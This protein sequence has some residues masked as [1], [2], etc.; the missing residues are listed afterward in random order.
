MQTSTTTQTTGNM[1]PTYIRGI[2]RDVYL[3]RYQR[4]TAQATL[5]FPELPT[6][7]AAA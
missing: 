5:F 3:S 7:K 6:I 2:H 1:Q 4:I